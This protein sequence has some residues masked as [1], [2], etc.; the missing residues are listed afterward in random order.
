MS[1]ERREE[2][3]ILISG[4]GPIGLLFALGM[5]QQGYRVVL[6]D[7][8]SAIDERPNQDDTRMIALSKRS[9]DLLKRL[10][11]WEKVE[12]V[13]TPIESVH[14]SE[15]GYRHSVFMDAKQYDLPYFGALIPLRALLELLFAA[16]EQHPNIDY[17]P[18][19]SVSKLHYNRGGQVKLTLTHNGVDEERIFRW[20]IAAEGAHSR[21]RQESGIESITNDY[22]QAA[23]IATGRFALPHNRIAYERFTDRGPLALLPINER[24]MAIILITEREALPYW[25]ACDDQTYIDEVMGR[26]EPDLLGPLEAVS[27][28]FGWKL[29]LM[30]AKKLVR[31]QLILIGNSAHALHPIAGQGLNLG[32][33]DVEELLR[34]FASGEPT[35]RQLEDF[36]RER[37]RDIHLVVGATDFLVRAFGYQQSPLPKLRNI[38]LRSVERIGFLKR[39]IAHFGM[40]YPPRLCCGIK[41]RR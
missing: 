20:A 14:V 30:L 24:E 39:S 17:R 27:P 23:I 25:Q 16:L 18:N 22:E 5:E 34:C 21:L 15:R 29:S 19:T 9:C 4:A 31:E 38:A 8:N 10:A 26:F 36:S 1:S 3:K 28:R 11:L 7:R 6:V 40:G 12:N 35:V 33:R 13:A 37:L 32:V 2:Q 41:R